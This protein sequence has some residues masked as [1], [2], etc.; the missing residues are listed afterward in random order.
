LKVSVVIPT[1][2]RAGL[3]PE[4]IGCIQAQTFPREQYEVI[5]VDNASSDE[6][7]SVLQQKSQTLANLRIGVENKPGAAATRNAGLRMA[8]GDLVLFIDDDVR[9]E[10]TLI[11]KHVDAQLK[12]K[13][14]SVIGSISI[15]WGETTEP[16]WRYLRDHRIF[17]PYTP[18]NGAIDF[19]YYHTCNAST[20]REA[21]LKAGGFDEDFTRYGMED[22]E[23]GY[24][25]Q[26]DGS[27]MIFAPD[28][29]AI[30]F[31]FPAYRDFVDRCEDAGYSLGKMLE[32]HPELKSRFVKGGPV[33]RC[34]KHFHAGY[35]VF[36]TAMNPL[37]NS[38]ARW[39]RRRGNGSV[40]WLS[41][42]HYTWS[43]RYH[44]FLGYRR[45]LDETFCQ[46]AE[47]T[48]PFPSSNNRTTRTSPSPPAAYARERSRK[49]ARSN[50]S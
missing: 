10:E 38:L 42:A 41:D 32:L 34:L 15:P 35:K 24:R 3:L 7:R 12:S 1:K 28:A 14:A 39:E 37:L 31:R 40:S 2:N 23:L 26:K 18:S 48:A 47:Q 11:E 17:N 29:R 21:L 19:A 27:Q 22:I 30:H 46:T 33:I 8:S 44:F 25:L 6:T 36:A 49:A 5:I 20:P 4:T 45:Y 13:R 16:F 50:L 9:A 43:I